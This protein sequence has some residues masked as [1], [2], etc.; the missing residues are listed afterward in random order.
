MYRN[1]LNAFTIPELLVAML[2]SAIV[3]IAVLYGFQLVSGLLVSTQKRS[4]ATTNGAILYS[5]LNNDVARADSILR[6]GDTLLFYSHTL[7]VR[8]YTDSSRIIRSQPPRLD[9]LGTNVT[10]NSVTFHPEV[11]RFVTAIT[12]AISINGRPSTYTFEKQYDT[13]LLFEAHTSTIEK[14]W[15]SKY[16]K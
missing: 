5:S 1:K 10:I 13:A 7:R 15:E 9:T 16:R 8:Y 14:K 4:M 11:D 12:L 6:R 3:L 2:V